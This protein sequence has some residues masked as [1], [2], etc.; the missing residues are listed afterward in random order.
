M[1]M[2]DLRAQI[3]DCDPAFAKILGAFN[4]K[5]W[6]DGK[7]ELTNKEIAA[8]TGFTERRA[9]NLTALMHTKGWLERR[10]RAGG[11]YV[12]KK[13]IPAMTWAEA[14][15]IAR[16]RLTGDPQQRLL[17]L[18]VPKKTA[19][20]GYQNETDPLPNHDAQDTKSRR[21]RYQFETPY[22]NKVFLKSSFKDLSKKTTPGSA[23]GLDPAPSGHEK[24]PWRSRDGHSLLELTDAYSDVYLAFKAALGVKTEV[25]LADR[26]RHIGRGVRALV[27]EASK[28]GFDFDEY[29]RR[30]KNMPRHSFAV[31]KDLALTTFISMNS[32]FADGSASLGPDKKF[33]SASAERRRPGED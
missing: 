30:L 28:P 16:L 26:D 15:E 7:T 13:N 24:A 29:V 17:G 20:S 11:E 2:V 3:E 32:E 4:L 22:S 31:K 18:D 33:Y 6:K 23:K 21:T 1:A 25:A 5:G 27:A 14:H 9:S 10:R 8:Y 19:V 12:Y